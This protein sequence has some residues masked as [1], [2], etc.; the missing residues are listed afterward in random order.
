VT[1]D[2]ANK[3]T[4]QDQALYYYSSDTTQ[5]WGDRWDARLRHNITSGHWRLYVNCRVQHFGNS[6]WLIQSAE[7]PAG[8]YAHKVIFGPSGPGTWDVCNYAETHLGTPYWY[9]GKQPYSWIDCSGFVTA[10]KIQQLGAG[11]NTRYRFNS[12]GVKHYVDGHYIGP[13]GKKVIIAT[14]VKKE[15][16]VLRGD[17]VAI[18][19]KPKKGASADWDHIALIESCKKDSTGNKLTEAMIIHSR[20][21]DDAEN[22]RVRNNE[23]IGDYPRGKWTYK[24]LR[25][26]E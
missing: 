18:A 13:D 15:A 5:Q 2:S 1:R 16:D 20:G 21:S 6:I 10:V 25:F 22:R 9:G 4:G 23:L 14:K 3:V 8:R 19:K 24:F 26:A 11:N 7:G 12:N 17:L